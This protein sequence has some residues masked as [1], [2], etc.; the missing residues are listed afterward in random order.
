M[1][2]LANKPKYSYNPTIRDGSGNIDNLGSQPNYIPGDQSVVTIVDKP[3]EAKAHEEW[4]GTVTAFNS[5]VT[6]EDYVQPRAFWEKTLGSDPDQQERLVGNVAA[7][8]S[9]ARPNIRQSSYG[10]SSPVL[11]GC[12][13]VANG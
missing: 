10:K 8:L 7:S 4:V 1:Q 12:E 2:T 6:E 3:Y 13:G 5:V 11:M 9:K